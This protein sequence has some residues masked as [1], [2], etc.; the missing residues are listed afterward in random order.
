MN[1]AETVRLHKFLAA[2]GV[3]SRRQCEEFIRQGRVSV[4]GKTVVKMGQ[5]INPQQDRVT[6]AGRTITDREKK[7]YLLLYKPPG[8]ITSLRDP[9]GRPTI[10]DLVNI[11]DGSARLYPVGRLD[12]DSEGLILLT[13]DG[14][15]A[16]RLM[17]PKY[18]VAKEYQVL[19]RG[20]P[21]P[22]KL[23]LL[24][25][26]VPL[27]EG[28]TAPARIK[29]VKKGSSKSVLKITIH[30]G[31]KH[32]VKKMCAAVGHP[33]ISLTRTRYAFLNTTGL[34][35]GNQRMLSAAEVAALKRLVGMEDL[36]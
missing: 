1:E 27:K 15:L 31:K 4:N 33:V 16:Y 9:Q 17:H 34:R 20:C 21:S 23:R 8:Y 29:M 3:G 14:E 22:G 13:N 35:P 25:Q 10:M 30:E 28:T 5:L 12:F 26:G 24:S 2:A 36:F 11:K 18:K 7:Q 6:F 32:Q 19:V